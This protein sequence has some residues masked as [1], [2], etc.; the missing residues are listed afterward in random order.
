MGYD[1][2]L[3]MLAISYCE[4]VCHEE[5]QGIRAKVDMGIDMPRG[6]I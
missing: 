6:Y 1:V 3:K 5:L 2:F 4:S